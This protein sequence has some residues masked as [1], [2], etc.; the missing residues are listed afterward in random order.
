MQGNLN[1]YICIP[2]QSRGLTKENTNNDFRENPPV[3]IEFSGYGLAHPVPGCSTYTS[4]GSADVWFFDTDSSG[5]GIADGVGEWQDYGLDPSRFPRELLANCQ[6]QLLEYSPLLKSAG[7][8]EITDLLEDILYK[9]CRAVK[10][11]GSSTVLLGYYKGSFLHILSLGDSALLVLRSRGD[12]LTVAFKSASQQHCFNCPYQLAHLPAP[13]DCKELTGF[14][15]CSQDSPF[16]GESTTIELRPGD[17]LIVATD[18]LFDN[19]YDRDILE[20]C[21]SCVEDPKVLATQLVH[22]AVEKSRDIHYVS[23]FA[24]SAAMHRLRHSGG[25]P[26]DSTVIIGVV[27]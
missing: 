3:R 21:E 12:Y 16:D 23:P 18:G 5:F 9:S 10:S 2:N 7:E 8:F 22:A 26:D 1:N 25:K 13:G 24:K 4:E 14:E 6:A 20:I 17:L 27:S 15:G 11:Y 19:L